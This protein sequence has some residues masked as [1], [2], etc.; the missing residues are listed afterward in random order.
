MS[1]KHR[2]I[3]INGFRSTFSELT[4]SINIKNPN[5]PMTKD[6]DPELGLLNPYSLICCFILYLYS[7]EFGEPPLYAELNR[8]ARNMDT[9]QLKNLGPIAC[10][11]NLITKQAEDNRDKGD[12]VKPGEW[13]SEGVVY[14]IAGVFLVFRG[15]RI[16]EELFKPY[17]KNIFKEL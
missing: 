6:T 15:G 16:T 5:K 17:E 13:Y 9:T 14:N 4:K 10:A 7:M 8:C 12:K 11:L 3:I 2:D 1:K